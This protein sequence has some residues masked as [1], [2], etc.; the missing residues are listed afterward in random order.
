MTLI[1]QEARTNHPSVKLRRTSVALARASTWH[2]ASFGRHRQM[3]SEIRVGDPS[4]AA[5]PNI[6]L[7]RMTSS[8]PVNSDVT[9][10]GTYP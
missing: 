10:K 9:Q 7:R 2:G 1:F 4:E 3:T 6:S 8:H 5:L